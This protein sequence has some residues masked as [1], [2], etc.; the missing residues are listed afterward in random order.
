MVRNNLT[1]NYKK[2]EYILI[3]NKKQIKRFKMQI[4]Q[5]VLEQKNQGKYLGVIIDN[6]LNWESR[7]NRV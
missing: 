3:T 1:I 4:D 6:K 7:I 5:N 2:T